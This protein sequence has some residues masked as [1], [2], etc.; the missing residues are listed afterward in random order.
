MLRLNR[1]SSFP[2]A[3]AA[4]LACALAPVT[5]PALAGIDPIP[6]C[7]NL[8]NGDFSSG[9]AFWSPDSELGEFGDTSTNAL[10]SADPLAFLPNQGNIASFF[11]EASADWECLTPNGSAA[12]STVVLSRTVLSAT[13]RTLEFKYGAQYSFLVA[14]GGVVEYSLVAVLTN[15]TTGRMVKCLLAEGRRDTVFVPAQEGI[16]QVPFTTFRSCNCAGNSFI[17]VGN[18]IEIEI[19]FSVRADGDPVNSIAFIGGP[20]YADDFRF[21]NIL[22]VQPADKAQGDMMAPGQAPSEAIVTA[23]D[24]G[25]IPEGITGAEL[26]KAL[27]DLDG[28]G[29]VSQADLMERTTL[30]G[31]VDL[32]LSRA[33][34]NRD[35]IVDNADLELM[36]EIMSHP[37]HSDRAS[38]DVNGD[39]AVDQA[40]LNGMLDE[41]R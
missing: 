14:R 12:S 13:A 41:M 9:F 3:L 28:D 39:G 7:F 21:C 31:V 11:T 1:I 8:N 17:N 23:R 6:L 38:A 34:L 16:I 40:D 36:M 19:V 30:N 10:P 15:R 22:C 4:G 26:R 24:L 18:E 5:A 33:D 32:T 37:N 27:F 20:G 2:F 29:V 35:G 25:Q